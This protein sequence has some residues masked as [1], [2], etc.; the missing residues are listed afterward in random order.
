VSTS[1]DTQ[2]VQPPA[3]AEVPPSEFFDLESHTPGLTH[4]YGDGLYGTGTYGDFIPALAPQ[5][6]PQLVPKPPEFLPL[7]DP[8]SQ[9]PPVLVLKPPEFVLLPEVRP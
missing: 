5:L 2:P 7:A 6:V 8:V 9:N 1:P 4:T 3:A